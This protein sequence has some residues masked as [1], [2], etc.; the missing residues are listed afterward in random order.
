M[1]AATNRTRTL[2]ALGLGTAFLL[3]SF[4]PP[5]GTTRYSKPVV[6]AHESDAD[7]CYDRGVCALADN[8]YD[9]AATDLS[10]AIEVYDKLASSAWDEMMAEFWRPIKNR[11][12]VFSRSNVDRLSAHAWHFREKFVKALTKRAEAYSKNGQFREAIADY[13][14][15]IRLDRDAATYRRRAA[16]YRAVGDTARAE[17]DEKQADFMTSS[18]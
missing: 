9:R 12:A 5:W 17:L 15:A 6:E 2:V 1:P 16:A 14:E 18:K 13:S 7:G 3:I 4:L 10:K 8:D 11:R